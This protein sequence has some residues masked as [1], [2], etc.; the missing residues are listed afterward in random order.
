MNL[1]AAGPCDFHGMIMPDKHDDLAEARTAVC[2]LQINVDGWS[3]E[4]SAIA[5]RGACRPRAIR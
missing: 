1:R 5:H 3:R 4:I 2:A